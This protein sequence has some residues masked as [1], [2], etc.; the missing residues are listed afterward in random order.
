MRNLRLFIYKDSWFPGGMRAVTGAKISITDPSTSVSSAPAPGPG[1][2]FVLCCGRR[3][4]RSRRPQ[5]KTVIIFP[6][7]KF[8]PIYRIGEMIAAD[9]RAEDL[10]R[11]LARVME[12]IRASEGSLDVQMY[13]SQDDPARFLMIETWES[14]EAHQASVKNIPPEM[15]GEFRPLVKE[16]SKGSYFAKVE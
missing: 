7:R 12:V 16:S 5:H 11:F 10:R 14:A 9:G 8:M 2:G 6:R 1:F 15:I 4:L 3:E 13:Q